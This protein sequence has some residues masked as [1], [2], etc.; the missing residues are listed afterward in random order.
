MIAESHINQTI[1]PKDATRCLLTF[2]YDLYVFIKKQTD[3]GGKVKL[4]W[5]MYF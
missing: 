4:G 3:L 5:K 2:E 1:R